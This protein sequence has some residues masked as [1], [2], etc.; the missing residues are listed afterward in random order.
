EIWDNN[1]LFVIMPSAT[2]TLSDRL[3][4]LEDNQMRFIED[5]QINQFELVQQLD[6]PIRRLEQNADVA[7]TLQRVRDADPNSDSSGQLID[8]SLRLYY[9]RQ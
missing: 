1:T 9:K 5:H 8:T 6:L 7:S 2:T 3:T 4:T